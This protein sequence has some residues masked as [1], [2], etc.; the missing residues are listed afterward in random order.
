[1]CRA[2]F[3]DDWAVVAE[4]PRADY[5]LIVSMSGSYPALVGLIPAR[6]A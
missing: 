2:Q 6:G 5:Q 4:K 1:M 3:V